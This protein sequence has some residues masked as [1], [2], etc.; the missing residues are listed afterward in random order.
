MKSY[1]QILANNIAQL[2]DANKA[3]N[4]SNSSNSSNSNLISQPPMAQTGST[5]KAKAIDN[6]RQYLLTGGN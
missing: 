4:S 6:Y 5:E 1:G 3:E 2:A